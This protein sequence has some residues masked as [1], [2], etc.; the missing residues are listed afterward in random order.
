[1]LLSSHVPINPCAPLV[2]HPY[3]YLG[4]VAAHFPTGQRIVDRLSMNICQIRASYPRDIHLRNGD[5]LAMKTRPVRACYLLSIILDIIFC[6]SKYMI[7][8]RRFSFLSILHHISIHLR[9]YKHLFHFFGHERKC[10]KMTSYLAK[11]PYLTHVKDH[12]SI[13][14]NKWIHQQL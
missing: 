5:R 8:L 10:L 1:M 14:Q 7:L 2:K 6:L 9:N 3:R 12:L 11:F 13:H 4:R